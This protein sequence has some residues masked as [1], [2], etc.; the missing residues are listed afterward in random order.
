MK[1]ALVPYRDASLGP[2]S[3]PIT[4]QHC[5]GGLAKAIQIG[6]YVHDSFN[7]DEY[8]HYERVENG[9]FNWIVPGK[10]LAFSG[11]TQTP[12]AYVDGVKSAHRRTQIALSLSRKHDGTRARGGSVFACPGTYCCQPAGNRVA[13]PSAPCPM[14]HNAPGAPKAPDPQPSEKN[15]RNYPQN[16]RGK[17]GGG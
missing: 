10:F 17:V 8:E 7:P 9:D 6:W 4:V 1:P 2:P 12:I 11:P 13:T 14:L 3:Y 15:Q 5:L 16:S